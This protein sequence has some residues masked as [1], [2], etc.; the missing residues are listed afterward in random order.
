MNKKLI[1]TQRSDHVSERA[2]SNHANRLPVSR[3]KD[4]L[5][6]SDAWAIHQSG[7]FSHRQ[8]GEYENKPRLEAPHRMYS[9]HQQS[10]SEKF[11]I[12][13]SEVKQSQSQPQP[14]V[15]LLSLVS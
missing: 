6:Q 8:K 10:S 13:N 11:N 15:D 3:E 12:L 14:S 9:S 7:L 1:I 4:G 2:L 5:R